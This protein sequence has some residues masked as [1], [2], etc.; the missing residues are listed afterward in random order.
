MPTKLKLGTH[1][2]SRLMYCMCVCTGIRVLMLI[3]SFISSLSFSPI[4]KHNIF[5]GLQNWNSVMYTKLKQLVLICPFVSSLSVFNWQ[6]LSFFVCRIGTNCLWCLRPGILWACAH[7]LLYLFSAVYIR[8]SEYFRNDKNQFQK[9]YAFKIDV[10]S[11]KHIFEK[12]TFMNY[13]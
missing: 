11:W 1:M 8:L 7:C 6:T 3:Y 12:C 4:P 13:F 9:F 2:D 5:V 10:S